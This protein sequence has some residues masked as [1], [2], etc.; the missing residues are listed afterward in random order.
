MSLPSPTITMDPSIL[1][2]M[3]A[4]LVELARRSDGDLRKLL[5][6][7]F[8]FLNRRTDFY[9]IPHE[10]DAGKSHR[11]GFKEGEAEQL[12]L[13]AFRQFPLRKMPKQNAPA[14]DPPGQSTTTA[15][16]PSSTAVVGTPAETST[17]TLG[18]T[19]TRAAAGTTDTTT[20]RKEIVSRREEADEDPMASTRFTD[21]GKQYP[22]GNG[23]STKSFRWTQTLEEVT[24]IVALPKGTTRGKDL[25]VTIKSGAIA[26]TTVTNQPTTATNGEGPRTIIEGTLTDKI[27]P[28]ESTWS[29]EGGVV[30]LILQKVRKTWWDSVLV[31]DPK[32][33]TSLVDSRR[34]IDE[35]DESTQG[36]IRRIL[37][38]QRQQRLG[39]PTSDQILRQ[40]GINPIPPLPPGVEYIDSDT[41]NKAQQTKSEDNSRC[42]A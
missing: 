18:T 12:L 10:D 36:A 42:E 34:R 13:A 31:G 32:I 24:V 40:Q 8:S 22:V 19:G 23:G 17:A 37:F 25:A 9:C 28:Q 41:L 3:D 14:R 11:L 4:P 33:D 35:Y 15:A 21:E 20:S 26:V 27:N 2:E 7:F 39:Q 38:D 1:K 5:Y 16:A 30:L 29:I 6:T